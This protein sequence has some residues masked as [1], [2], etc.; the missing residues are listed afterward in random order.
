MAWKEEYSGLMLRAYEG[1]DREAV[2]RISYETADAGRPGDTICADREFLSDALTA[3]YTDFE[4]ASSLVADSG[5]SVVG[6][7][8]GC[9]NTRR[10]LRLTLLAV[11]PGAVARAAV[12]G[13]LFGPDIWRIAWS[14]FRAELAVPRD[15]R[16]SLPRCPAHLHVNLLPEARAKGVARR[17]VERFLEEAKSAGVPGVH[18]SV[19]ED[20]AVAR[21]FFEKAGFVSLGRRPTMLVPRRHD[22]RLYSVIYAK[23]L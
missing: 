16:A 13:T 8:N 6:Y 21:H 20:N 12:R 9:L 10:S 17:L 4:P 1:R 2:R 3:Y 18:A 5:G 14:A 19:R 11:W 22:R 7:L 15:L 23:A